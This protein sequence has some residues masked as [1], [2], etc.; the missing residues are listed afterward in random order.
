MVG[1]DIMKALKSQMRQETIHMDEQEKSH[2][3]ELASVE[4][5]EDADLDRRLHWAPGAE[6]AVRFQQRV[7]HLQF[8]VARARV[9]VRV[10]RGRGC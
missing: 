9:C 2:A 6:G 5:E 8:C 7:P 4:E 10:G 3:S 1:I